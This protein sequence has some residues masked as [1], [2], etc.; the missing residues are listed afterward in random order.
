MAKLIV[1]YEGSLMIKRYTSD[2]GNTGIMLHPN[3]VDI[4]SR[5]GKMITSY[6][7]KAGE[8][9]NTAELIELV[10]DFPR[11]EAI[12]KANVLCDTQFEQ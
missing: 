7:K 4:W 8:A 2:E 10:E 11:K 1:T 5:E 12:R 3:Q 6:K 9:Y